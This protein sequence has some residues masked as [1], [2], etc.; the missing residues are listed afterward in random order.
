MPQFSAARIVAAL[1]AVLV[2]SLLVSC[3]GTG[4]S[5]NPVTSLA[6]SPT[7]L[8]LSPGQTYQFTATPKNYAG[9]A[10]VADVSYSSSNTSL[11]TVTAGG[12]V[13][14]GVWDQNFITCNPVSGQAAV[15]QAV[16]TANSQNVTTTAI[17]YTHLQVDRIFVTPPAGCVSVGATPTYLA[18]VYNTTAP[19]C[20]P[21]IP[22][23]I[24]STVGPIT[25]NSTDLDVMTNN[26]TSGVL[27]AANPGATT[28]YASVSGLH[29]IPQPTSV[30]PVVSIN[31]HDAASSNTTFSLAP[32]ATQNL[33]ADVIDSNGVAISPILTWSSVPAGVASVSAT[34][35]TSTTTPPPNAF[36]V[37]A[38]TGGTTTIT[39]TCSTPDCNRN[40]G[41][42]YGQNIVTVNVTGGTSTTVYAGSTNSLSLIP[43]ASSNN[44]AG[45]AIVLPYLPNSIVT[46]SAGTK[47]YL[48]SGSGLMT[49]DVLT[50]AVTV[51]A[52]VPG[53]VLAASPDGNYLLIS[54][55]ASGFV[56]LYGT[57]SSSALLTHQLTATAAAFTPDSKSVT[58]L[59]GQTIYYDTTTPL[60]SFSNLSF[61]PTA[62][63]LSAQGGVT[64]VTGSALGAIDVR[65]T[66]NQAEWQTLTAT[67]PTLVAHLPNGTGAVV[68]DSPNLDVVTTAAIPQGCPPNPQNTMNTY[69]LGF[70]NFTAQQIFVST[71]SGAAW[72]LSNLPAV[73]ALDLTKFTPFSIALANS[74]QPLSGGVTVDGSFVYVGGSD[75]NV[76]SLSVANHTDSAQINPGL[77][78]GSGNAVAPNLVLVLPK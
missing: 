2:L 64:Y 40:L 21:N 11:V 23:D 61:T 37:T 55:N 4:T 30:C 50:A 19:G 69:N 33:V 12:L 60:S 58:F 1:F 17:V 3:S 56:Y 63:D 73:L 44:T 22:C 51:S 29:S 6:L 31:V 57:A 54:N 15:G 14:A 5:P 65:T 45:T 67:Q 68:A 72:I 75:M 48:G 42:Q 76:H 18:T 47:V 38:N 36:T 59:S 7:Y 46:N 66:C 62:V 13:C 20:S 52:N 25:F 34:T 26:T 43:I 70:G 10:I 8:S 32:V 28:I 27:T 16:I 41:P 39:V 9:T 78:D 77:K 49:V 74:A 53:T 71:N 35:G 24:T